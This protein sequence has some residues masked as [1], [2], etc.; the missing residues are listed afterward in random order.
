MTTESTSAHDHPTTPSVPDDL[1]GDRPD[2]LLDDLLE[3]L[4]DA[5]RPALPAGPVPRAA[6]ALARDLEPDWLVHHS[7]RSWLF[8]RVVA[9]GRGWRADVDFDDETLFVACV[10]HDA[11]L[12]AGP[13]A[14]RRFE[15]DGADLARAFAREQG[16]SARAVDTV[17]DAVALHTSVGIAEHKQAEVALT[18]AGV[19]MDFGFGARA[20]PDALA[21]ALDAHLPR[22]DVTRRLVDAIVAHAGDSPH[23]A[24]E[25]SLPARFVHERGVPPHVT[26]LERAA[27]AGRWG[28]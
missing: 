25:G 21:D 19:A 15:V 3:G 12:H 16:L 4:L 8:A 20:V 7:V 13:P 2:D 10:L 17:W 6:L 14:E 23:R 5:G 26:S 22:L 24:P 1:P 27:A 18:A 28:G 11:G 9:A